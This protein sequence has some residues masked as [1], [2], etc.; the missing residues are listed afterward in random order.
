MSGSVFSNQSGSGY[1]DLAGTVI[2]Y[3]YEDFGDFGGNHIVINQ[4][5]MNVFDHISPIGV[6]AE[7]IYGLSCFDLIESC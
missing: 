7:S 1:A 3:T 5:T 2:I 4:Q 6:R